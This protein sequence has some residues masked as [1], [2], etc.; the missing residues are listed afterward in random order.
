[1]IVPRLKEHTH[2][3]GVL[4]TPLNTYKNITRVPWVYE[5][6][7]EL[8]WVALIFSQYDRRVGFQKFR[9]ILTK[10]FQLAPS[11]FSIRISDIL[12]LDEDKQK[13]FYQ[14]VVAETSKDFLVPLT[15]TLTASIAPVFAESFYSSMSIEDRLE[16]LVRG[17]NQLMNSQSDFSTDIRYIEL[18]PW[19]IRKK[20]HLPR[21]LAHKINLYEKLSHEDE[22]IEFCRSFI[23]AAGMAHC[24]AQVEK[25]PFIEHFWKKISKMTD[26]ILLERPFPQETRNV[27]EYIGGLKRILEYLVELQIG[28]APLCDRMDVILGITVYLLRCFEEVCQSNLANSIVARRIVRGIFENYI[29][30]K[31]LVQKEAGNKNIWAEFKDYGIGQYKLALLAAREANSNKVDHFDVGFIEL[32]VNEFISEIFT[33]IDVRYFPDGKNI[34]DKAKEVGEEELHKILYTY[35]SSFEHGLWGAIRESVFFKCGNPAHNFHCVPNI[36][37]EIQLKTVLPD[38]IMLMNKFVSLLHKL[39]GIPSELLKGV[40]DFELKPLSK[41]TD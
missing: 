29:M 40:S 36:Y 27:D 13:D 33:D 17:M 22:G 21:N 25:A 14:F 6:M 19:L 38:C 28:T 3:R 35:D 39:C 18:F 30:L 4:L 32:L 2:H 34:K 7:P 16:K 8:L 23:R 37:G 9:R 12:K 41:R 5:R 11:L 1:M 10:L 20:L 26:C 15:V 31:F 24:S